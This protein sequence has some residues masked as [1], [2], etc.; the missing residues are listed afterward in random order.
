MYACY[1]KD[2]NCRV[3]AAFLSSL[4]A[5]CTCAGE[6]LDGV[7]LPLPVLLVGIARGRTA[8]RRNPALPSR[9]APFAVCSSMPCDCTQQPAASQGHDV[10]AW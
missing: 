8:V 3:W 6:W 4:D 7:M 1:A 5:V 10:L 2:L 9:V